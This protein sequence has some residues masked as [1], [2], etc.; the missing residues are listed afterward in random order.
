MKKNLASIAYLLI[1]SCSKKY[2][3]RYLNKNALHRLCKTIDHVT[4][5][6]LEYIYNSEWPL[7]INLQLEKEKK[8]FYYLQ[9]M[10]K[11]TKLS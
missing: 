9:T 5:L 3:L 8:K 11:I 2:T 7:G 10:A 1:S 6:I 4:I